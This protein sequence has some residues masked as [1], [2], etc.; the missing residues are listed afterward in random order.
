MNKRRENILNKLKDK[1][2]NLKIVSQVFGD[3][4]VD[5]I[6]KCDIV[7]NLHYYP[8]AILEIFRIH[9]LLPYDC[10]ILSENPG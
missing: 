9:D 7:L 5:E 1:G 8:N 4:L 10:K 2:Y 3:E 6:K